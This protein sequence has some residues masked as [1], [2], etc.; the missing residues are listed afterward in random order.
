[1]FVNMAFILGLNYD[2]AEKL[3]NLNG[4]TFE[5]VG[6][7]FDVICRKAFKIGFSRDMTI[8]LI[9]KRNRELKD[10][11]KKSSSKKKCSLIPNLTSNKG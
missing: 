3:L 7:Q 4:Y 1:M 6:R 9:E 8:A 11:L 10:S 5:S 2:G